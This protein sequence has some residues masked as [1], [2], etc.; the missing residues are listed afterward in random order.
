M[1]LQGRGLP[2]NCPHGAH[3]LRAV[4]EKLFQDA[5][6]SGNTLVPRESVGLR[7]VARDGAFAP[8]MLQDD[9]PDEVPTPP[10][11]PVLLAR[12]APCW[13][14]QSVADE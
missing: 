5:S 10:R 4:A 8:D 12:G 9:L 13:L 3:Y 7:D 6:A 14:L 1:C 11:P 2:Q